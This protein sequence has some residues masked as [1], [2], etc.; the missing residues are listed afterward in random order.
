MKYY[1]G[2]IDITFERVDAEEEEDLYRKI[3]ESVPGWMHI[4]CINKEYSE[5]EEDLLREGNPYD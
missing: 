1:T 3:K 2:T 4:T 5:T